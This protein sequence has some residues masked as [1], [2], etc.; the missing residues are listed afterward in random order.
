MY[1]EELSFMYLDSQDN[2][3]VGHG[4]PRICTSISL[5]FW[6]LQ[7]E[8]GWRNRQQ[9]SISLRSSMINGIKYDITVYILWLRIIWQNLKAKSAS[10]LSCWSS[11]AASELEKCCKF[12]AFM[13]ETV[14]WDPRL[15]QNFIWILISVTDFDDQIWMR[16]HKLLR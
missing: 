5:F 2:T 7:R 14:T 8:A 15:L 6:L 16:T 4:E 11:L 10:Q 1:K 12:Y 13:H 3:G 9:L